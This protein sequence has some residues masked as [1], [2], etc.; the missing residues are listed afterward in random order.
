MHITWSRCGIGTQRSD[1]F[2]PCLRNAF[3]I[4]ARTV[5]FAYTFQQYVQQILSNRDYRTRFFGRLRN[6]L[7][8]I[9]Q[10]F[11]VIATFINTLGVKSIRKI[12]GSSEGVRSNIHTNRSPS[13]VQMCRIAKFYNVSLINTAWNALLSAVEWH[14]PPSAVFSKV[15]SDRWSY[16]PQVKLLSPTLIWCRKSRENVFSPISF[17]YFPPFNSNHPKN[18]KQPFTK[19]KFRQ[20]LSFNLSERIAPWMSY[21]DVTC[22]LTM[23][24]CHA[25]PEKMNFFL[26]RT[27]ECIQWNGLIF[28]VNITRLNIFTEREWV[29]YECK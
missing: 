10:R 3:L 14:A 13:G 25:A 7:V 26:F 16:S 1:H 28:V 8:M 21:K 4:G 6:R 17:A 19:N 2:G 12:R 23:S 15:H 22:S 11:A 29:E 18:E 27:N 5:C 24:F 20:N 9:S